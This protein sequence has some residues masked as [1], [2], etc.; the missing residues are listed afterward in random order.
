MSVPRSV[1]GSPTVQ[2]ASAVALV[3]AAR[4]LH[5]RQSPQGG[6]CFYRTAEV[7]EPNLFDTYHAV[8]ALTLLGE[9]VARGD[10]LLRF[11]ASFPPTAQVSTLYYRAFVLHYLG[12]DTLIERNEIRRLPLAPPAPGRTPL[13]SVLRVLFET[14]RLKRLL[15]DDLV[16]PAVVRW[17]TGTQRDGGFGKKPNLLDTRHAL[18]VLAALGGLTQPVA[19]AARDFV[20]ALQVPTF[21]FAV[22]RDSLASSLETLRAGIQCCR[23]LG[24]GIQHPRELRAFVLACQT[25]E[26]G[27]S[28]VPGALPEIE[29][30]H[31]GIAILRDLDNPHDATDSI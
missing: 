6:F 10:A 22:T 25:S 1:Q 27:L 5:S 14:V 13:S 16:A 23:L 9:T 12:R 2:E 3:R 31:Y 26:G 28:R 4:Y 30:T 19:A 15:G 11:L 17:I 24:L 18:Y 8:A 29:S 7:D 21:G 20:G